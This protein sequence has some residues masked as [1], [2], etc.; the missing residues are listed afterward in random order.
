MVRDGRR[1]LPREYSHVSSLAASIA[2][3]KG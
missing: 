1:L 3:K 2:L